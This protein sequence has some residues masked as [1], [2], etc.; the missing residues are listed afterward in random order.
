VTRTRQIGDAD[1]TE[2]TRGIGVRIHFLSRVSASESLRTSASA[3]DLRLRH[4]W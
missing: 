3:S 2:I 4:V 1:S